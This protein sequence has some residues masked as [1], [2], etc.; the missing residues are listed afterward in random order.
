MG[1]CSCRVQP[2]CIIA[3]AEMLRRM[4][5]LPYRSLAAPRPYSALLESLAPIVK[6]YA[7]AMAFGIWRNDVAA[8]VQQTRGDHNDSVSDASWSTGHSSRAHAFSSSS[9]M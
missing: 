7:P 3:T 8:A 6:P 1:S 9:G 2:R 4:P 5:P